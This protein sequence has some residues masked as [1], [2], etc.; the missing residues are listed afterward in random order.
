[1]TRI[2]AAMMLL[3]AC[4]A[5][6]SKVEE[7]PGER[8]AARPRETL[9]GR[10]APAAA[11]ELLDGER[12]QLGDLFG[13]KPVY[14]KFWAT[15]CVPCQKQTP[16]LEATH[17]KYGDRIATFAVD[18]GIN[19]SVEAVREFQAAH[20]MTVPIAIDDGS[21]AERFHVAV[22]P[23]HIL[24]D[25]AGVVRHVGHAATAELDRAIESLL[26]DDP[27]PRDPPQPA[28]PPADAPPSLTLLDGSTF[29]LSAHAGRPIALTF[30]QASCDR[31]LAR[32]RPAMAEACAAHAR[33]IES[34]RPTAARVVWVTI[35]HPVWTSTDSLDA[36]RKRHA[37]STPIGVDETATWFRRFR[38]RDV[39]TTILL[40]ERGAEIERVGGRGDDLPRAL[41]RFR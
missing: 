17:R 31:Y 32:S 9:V 30:V 13:R 37:V 27:A 11:L 4:R 35:A 41:A 26:H 5:P 14:L 39:P 38:V 2:A 36:Y 28:A 3:L 12:V 24:V 33:Q 8:H 25:R 18:L 23:Q 1:V 7:D 21:L 40:D 34:L 20:A 19:D 15:W 10:L 16:H 6:D 29:T 22:T